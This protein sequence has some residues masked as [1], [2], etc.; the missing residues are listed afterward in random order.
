MGGKLKYY[1]ELDGLRGF[2]ALTIFFFHFL[3]GQ[4]ITGAL[5]T[6]AMK[7][8]SFGPTMANL[9]FVLSGFLI[10]Q[11]LLSAKGSDNFFSRYYTRRILRIFPL[12][13]LA[14]LIYFFGLP[15]LHHRT[16]PSWDMQWFNW[17]HLQNL[18]LT[19]RWPHAGPK[20]L[21]S[22]AVEEHFYMLWPL[23]V[24]WCN[25]RQMITCSVV[26]FLVAVFSRF[27]LT[28]NHYPVFYF[29]FSTMDALSIGAIAG[30]LNYHND[31]PKYKT[32]IKATAIAT[33]IPTVVLWLLFFGTKNGT[34]HTLM[35]VAINIFYASAL[36][37]IVQS[38]ESNRVKKLLTSRALMFVGTVSYGLFIFHP[39]CIS[40]TRR[41]LSQYDTG[42]QLTVSLIASI[43]V[44]TLSYFLFERWFMGLRIYKG[45]TKTV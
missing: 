1:K 31:F 12:Y 7:L 18:P 41:V 38:G 14:S 29:T 45:H 42:L 19:F 30:I 44:A 43:A 40:F 33:G 8:I 5:P 3:H 27:I 22:L 20:Y 17:V 11:I 37:L 4:K 36:C 2:A 9:F 39:L 21:W 10:T 6:A 26:I 13:Y 15:L 32:G 35:P 23:L 16:L 34:F 25:K 28:Q 24:F